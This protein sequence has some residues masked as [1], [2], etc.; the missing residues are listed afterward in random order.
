MRT[1]IATPVTFRGDRS[2]PY[3]AVAPT[4]VLILLLGF[5][6]AVH[7][8]IISLHEYKLI[9][10]P[11]RFIWFGNYLTL[12]TSDPR[13]LH[14]LVFTLAFGFVAT[15]VELVVGFFI[16]YLLADR[17]VSHRFSSLVRTALLVPFVSAPVVMSYTFKTLIYDQTF[18]YLNYFLGLAGLPKYDIFRGTVAAPAGMLVLEV[19]LRTPFLAI[20]LYAGI[21]S[22]SR[23][24]HDAADIDGVTW[25]KKIR[26][27]IIPLIGPIIMIGFILRFMDA[28]KMFDE[29]FVVTGGGPGYVTENISLF[30]AKQAFTYFNMGYAAAS[31]FLFLLI[32]V[33]LVNISMRRLQV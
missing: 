16:A 15:S 3:V 28:L 31:A 26:L 19:I 29:M 18:G 23:S 21:A 33:V 30:A 14:A 7:G 27:I 22:I 8:F 9:K 32:V 20:I 4:V 11:A 5:L 6:P 17:E 10:P 1:T 2:F 25:F 24:I 12:I 13:F